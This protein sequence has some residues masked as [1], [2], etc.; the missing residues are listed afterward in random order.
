MK[1]KKTKN[2]FYISGRLNGFQV[3]LVDTDQKLN[4]SKNFDFDSRLQ[5]ETLEEAESFK[6]KLEAREKN[7]PNFSYIIEE[8][9]E[10]YYSQ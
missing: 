3:G 8:W 5:F 2:T 10:D 4:Y 6:N 9:E 1:T 7:N